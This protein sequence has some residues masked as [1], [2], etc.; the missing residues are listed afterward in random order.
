MKWNQKTIHQWGINTFGAAALN[1]LGVAVRMARETVE[2]SSYLVVGDDAEKVA[3][4]AADVAI[5]LLQVA[6]CLGIDTEMIALNEDL[7]AVIMNEI[8]VSIRLNT[9]TI[10][11]ISAVMNMAEGKQIVNHIRTII[12][13]LHALE[14]LYEF[15]LKEKI[16]IKMDINE[17]RQWKQNA[18][19]SFQHV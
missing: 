2:L 12:T 17:A 7:D 14:E 9:A 1:T 15:D 5:V 8:D 13:C 19:G 3:M 11:L 18:D 6:N 16:Q 4:E 10:D